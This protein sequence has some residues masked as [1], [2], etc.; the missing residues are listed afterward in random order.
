ME[1]LAPLAVGFVSLLLIPSL[2]V[3]A[4]F[5]RRVTPVLGAALVAWVLGGLWAAATGWHPGGSEERFR[6]LWLAGLAVGFGLFLVARLR[7]KRGTWRWVRLTMAALT[8]T[9]FVR[10]LLTYLH[11]Y[12]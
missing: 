10:A 5:R 1:S 3:L 2:G 8:V 9:V 12:A 7:E 4:L 6:R 11:A